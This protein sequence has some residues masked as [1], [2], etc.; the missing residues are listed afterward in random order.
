MAYGKYAVNNVDK[1]GNEARASPNSSQ[2]VRTV[3]HCDQGKR[4][5]SAVPGLLPQAERPESCIR[6]GGA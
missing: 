5:L 3:R 2:A 4:V 6:H 1:D